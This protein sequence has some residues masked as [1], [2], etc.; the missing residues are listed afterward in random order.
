MNFCP[1]KDSPTKANDILKLIFN[2]VVEEPVSKALGISEK[3]LR[4]NTFDGY[5]NNSISV[6]KKQT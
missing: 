2:N 4:A 5:Y 3:N 1:G 6:I